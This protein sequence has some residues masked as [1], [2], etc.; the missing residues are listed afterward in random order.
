MDV[1]ENFTYD[2][3][4]VGDTATFTKTLTEDQIILFA[5]VSGDMNPVHLDPKFAET[6]VFK[7]RIAHGMWSG[8]LISAAIATVLPGPGSI[9]LEQSMAFLRPV[10]IN[11]ILTARITVTEKLPKGRVVLQCEIHNQNDEQVV[12]GQAKVIAPKEKMQVDKPELPE[13]TIG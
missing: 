11:D 1:L 5:A 10:K 13:I 8:A 3:L 2:E 9:Y 12:S 6:T 7:E 4:D